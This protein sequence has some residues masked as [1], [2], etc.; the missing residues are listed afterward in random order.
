MKKT[1][2]LA[3]LLTLAVG[4][5][6]RPPL[7]GDVDAGNNSRRDGQVSGFDGHVSRPDAAAYDP[8]DPANAC[9]LSTIPTTQ[10][11]GTLMIVFDRSGSMGDAPSDSG[12]SKWELATSAIDSVLTPASLDDLSAGLMLF[13]SDGDCGAPSTP[14][15]AI[16]ELSTNRS[17]IHDALAGTGPGGNTPAF[18][19]LLS[20]YDYLH[21][22]STSGQLGVVLVT[23]GGES[24]NL[25]EADSVMAR[26]QMEHDTR[27][28][29]TFAVGLDYADNNLSTIAYNGGTPRNSTCMPTCTS[30]SCLTDADCGGTARCVT[31]PG[32]TGVAGFC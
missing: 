13:P 5:D 3:A 24:C 12:P 19:A 17:V 31:P 32:L 18:H 8:F 6:A 30:G 22:L 29:L 4:C 25:D 23:D 21:T 28:I 20:A 9:G 16:A 27:N 15:V 11:P 10:V 7:I 1:V 14:D 26:V 2:Y